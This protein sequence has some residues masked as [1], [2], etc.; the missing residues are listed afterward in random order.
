M[1]PIICGLILFM[2]TVMELKTSWLRMCQKLMKLWYVSAC[3]GI[4]V[5]LISLH[6]IFES[7]LMVRCLQR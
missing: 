3:L 7:L 1:H 4:L 2:L 5:D 6:V